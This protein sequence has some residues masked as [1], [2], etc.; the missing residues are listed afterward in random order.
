MLKDK[1]QRLSAKV[2]L[3]KIVT[4]YFEDY[5]GL[6][7]IDKLIYRKTEKK[8]RG[9]FTEDLYIYEVV[10]TKEG[11]RYII[12]E[13]LEGLNFEAPCDEWYA[14]VYDEHGNILYDKTDS[15]AYVNDRL[16]SKRS[17]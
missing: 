10:K 11:R 4:D 12:V 13:A 1:L 5:L 17:R 16:E 8:Q 15:D 2:H 9:E 14:L 6:G 3:Y 7:E